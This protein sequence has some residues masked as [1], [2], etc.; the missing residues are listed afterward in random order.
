MKDLQL[1][2]TEASGVSLPFR[3]GEM[4]CLA[5]REGAARGHRH[6]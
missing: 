2:Y 1:V 3:A 5:G 4:R 6:P